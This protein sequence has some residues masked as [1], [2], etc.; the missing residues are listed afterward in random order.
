M[1]CPEHPAP[2]QAEAR[3]WPS[4][5][6]QPVPRPLIIAASASVASGLGRFRVFGHRR[7][8]WSVPH[9]QVWA[10]WPGGPGILSIHAAGLR[11]TAGPPGSRLARTGIGARPRQS[12]QPFSVSGAWR[13][14]VSSPP[15]P[16]LLPLA[17]DRSRC[18]LWSRSF[19]RCRRG[20]RTDRASRFR[21]RLFSVPLRGLATLPR[22]G[23]K[24]FASTFGAC[25]PGWSA[26]LHR[27]ALMG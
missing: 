8:L 5:G 23:G 4:F 10:P 11:R 19:R 1:G 26:S 2:G 7:R 20:A 17:L 21:I 6:N 3:D 27:R 25:V 9:F 18:V 12:F 22:S 14:C 13:A 24:P 15:P 16:A